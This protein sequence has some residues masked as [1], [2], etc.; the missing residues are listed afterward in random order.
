MEIHREHGETLSALAG[1]RIVVAGY[2]NQGRPQALN[3][4]DSGLDVVVAARPGRPGWVRAAKDG[5]DVVTIADG[6]S[7]ADVLMILLPDEVQG[8]VWRR[9]IAGAIRRGATLC[10]AHGFAVAFG[11]IEPADADLV[12]V[13]PKGQGREVRAAFERGS[14]LPCL[15]A[16]A[17]DVSGRARGRALGIAAGLGC[18]RV[19]GIETTFREEAVSDLFGEQAVLCG[20]VPAIVKRAFEVLTGRGFSPEVAYFECVHELKIIVD[21]VAERGIAG[22][23]DLISGTAAYGSLRFGEDLVDDETTRRMEE[24][25]ERIDSGE[26]ARDWLAESREGARRLAELRLLERGLP[27]ESVGREVR[28]LFPENERKGRK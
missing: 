14:G 11:E 3:L 6:A 17:H 15:F 27:I 7:G 21:L 9:E 18:L 5:F 19:G 4:R 16:V 24:I 8:E 1:E 25:F 2:G 13:A 22:M 23:R 12:L 10:F 26:F 20:G 28:S